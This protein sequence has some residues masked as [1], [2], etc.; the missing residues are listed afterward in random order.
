[1]KLCRIALAFL[2]PVI[3]SS[4]SMLIHDYQFLN[5]LNDSLGGP[6]LVSLGGTVGSGNYTFAA[7]QGLSLSNALPNSADYSLFMDFE[8]F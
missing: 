8:F 7:E 5:N 2:L 1:M 4:A 6:S 3:H